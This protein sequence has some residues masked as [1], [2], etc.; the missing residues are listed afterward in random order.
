VQLKSI[1]KI[2]HAVS[3]GSALVGEMQVFAKRVKENTGMEV[4]IGLLT[5]ADRFLADTSV[6]DGSRYCVSSKLVAHSPGA[7]AEQ[8]QLIAR[9]KEEQASKRPRLS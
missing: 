3:F 2:S 7:S 8:L 4:T 1:T 6:P 9:A 5:P